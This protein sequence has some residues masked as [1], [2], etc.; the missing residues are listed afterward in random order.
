MLISLL[1]VFAL[2]GGPVAEAATAVA[3][4]AVAPQAQSQALA[5]TAPTLLFALPSSGSE[6]DPVVLVGTDFGNGAL[7]FFGFIPSAPLFTFNSPELPFIG[8]ISVM[9]TAVPFTFFPGTVDLTVIRG[10]QSSN[11]IDFTIL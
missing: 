6:L 5:R 9:L 10:F 1:H 4:A 2:T 11:S 3:P 8:S 7:P